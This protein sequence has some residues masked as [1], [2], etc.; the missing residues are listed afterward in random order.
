[1]IPF[2]WWI[3][4]ITLISGLLVWGSINFVIE[5]QFHPAQSILLVIQILTFPAWMIQ[6][7]TLILALRRVTH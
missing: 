6:G 5:N 3:A 2:P 1:V 7:I 4:G